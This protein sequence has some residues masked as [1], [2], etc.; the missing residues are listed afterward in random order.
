MMRVLYHCA[1]TAAQSSLRTCERLTYCYILR[2]HLFR[3]C[4]V[5]L[6]DLVLEEDDCCDGGSLEQDLPELGQQLVG[7]QHVG[8]LGL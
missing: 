8:H 4:C 6:L 7:G 3:T 2:M 1:T 5:S